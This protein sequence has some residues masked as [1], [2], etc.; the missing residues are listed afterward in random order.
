M[1]A[2][3]P[4]VRRGG[5]PGGSRRRQGVRAA[6]GVPFR[7][8]RVASPPAVERARQDCELVELIYWFH[9]ESRGTYGSPRIHDEPPMSR[10]NRSAGT[11]RSRRSE[12]LQAACVACGRPADLHLDPDSRVWTSADTGFGD[13]LASDRAEAASSVNT[14]SLSGL[15]NRRSVAVGGAL[16]TLAR[17]ESGSRPC[18]Q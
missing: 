4:G 5:E 6:R 18:V 7:L 9:A 17:G 13:P 11:S 15:P 16:V 12:C 1:T 3:V 14:P 2:Q 10:L 8:L